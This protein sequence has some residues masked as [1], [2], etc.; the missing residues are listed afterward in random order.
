M[1]VLTRLLE[2]LVYLFEA[3]VHIDTRLLE[4][5][6]HVFTR[7][8]E[9]LLHEAEALLHQL[10]LR[11]QLLFDADH[12]LEVVSIHAHDDRR[13]S[14]ADPFAKVLPNIGADLFQMVARQ[15][16]RTAHRVSS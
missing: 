12:A 2:P 6:V 11:L 16:H 7:L 1:H 14:H 9:A 5:G 4:A 15:F 13:F 8:L 10:A 3:G